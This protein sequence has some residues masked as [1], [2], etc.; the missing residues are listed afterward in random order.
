MTA[1]ALDVY[2]HGLGGGDVLVEYD[3]GSVWTLPVAR[4]RQRLLPGDERLLARLTG[5]V[6][7][8]GCG[9]GRL[10]AALTAR[11]VPALGIDICPEAVALTK[12]NGALAVRRD[13]FSTL[14]GVGRWP[15][16][17]LADGNVG[18]GGRPV[19]LLRRIAELLGPGGCVHVETDPPGRES[20]PVWAR[21]HGGGMTSRWF[22]WAHVTAGDIAA[23]GVR[24]GLRRTDCWT[25]AG[26]WFSV[27]TGC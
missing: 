23:F 11:G 20:R 25:E 2:A 21:L 4:W 10:T 24:A 16:V 12:A 19:L 5:P 1:T 6:L 8:V 9:P 7:D 3:D 26:R 22:A 14:P 15:T 27:L 13:V 18:I 17:L